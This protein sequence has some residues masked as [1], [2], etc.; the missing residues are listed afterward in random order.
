MSK[1]IGKHVNIQRFQVN[2]LKI[3]ITVV[4]APTKRPHKVTG[5]SRTC[6]SSPTNRIQMLLGVLEE[7]YKLP[8]VQL[9]HRHLASSAPSL[10]VVNT[11]FASYAGRQL[12]K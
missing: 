6:E 1:A 12:C 9:N 11:N 8:G 10:R 7:I 2:T 4:T 5:G 3:A